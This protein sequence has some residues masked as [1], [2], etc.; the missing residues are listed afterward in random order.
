M[1]CLDG[2]TLPGHQR[3]SCRRCKAAYAR[4]HRNLAYAR[5]RYRAYRGSNQARAHNQ[6]KGAVRSGILRSIKK[7]LCMDCGMPAT[8]YDHRDYLKPLDV[9]PVCTRCN[10]KR[11][12]GENR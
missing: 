4:R 5:E 8:C 12:P 6:V 9:D 10:K 2:V 1:D 7:R 11:G 3:R